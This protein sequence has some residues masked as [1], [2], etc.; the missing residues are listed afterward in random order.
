MS[1]KDFEKFLKDNANKY[2][3]EEKEV[4][5]EK[6]KKEWLEFIEIF[7]NQVKEWLKPYIKQGSLSISFSE[8]NITEDHIGSYIVNKMDISLAG[9]TLT[10]DPIG[11]LLIGTKGRIDLSGPKGSVKFILTDMNS[12]GFNISFKVLSDNEKHEP[13]TDINWTWKIIDRNSTGIKFIDFN[14]NNFFA[15]LMGLVN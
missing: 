1:R 12:K 7:Y 13:I 6:Q 5:W 9:A 14:E 4:D 2:S 15:S 8:K 10:L 11:T 3:R